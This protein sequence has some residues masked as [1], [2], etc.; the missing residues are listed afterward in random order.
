MIQKLF[1]TRQ[2]IAD[3]LGID[4]KTFRRYLKKFDIDLK[5]GLMPV[6]VADEIMEIFKRFRLSDPSS[7][8]NETKFDDKN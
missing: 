4:V 3:N 2:Q 7:L 6:G 1:T 5:P 8:N